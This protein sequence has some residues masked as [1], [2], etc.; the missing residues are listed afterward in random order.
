MRKQKK[1]KRNRKV[2]SK[3]EKKEPIEKKR[4]QGGRKPWEKID[5]RRKA[6]Y[7]KGRKRRSNELALVKSL[8]TYG[9][10]ISSFIWRGLDE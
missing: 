10:V 9:I 4:K 7:L 8:Q 5:M 6:V 3:E 1:I 2:R